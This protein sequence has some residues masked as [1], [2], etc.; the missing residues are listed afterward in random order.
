MTTKICSKC[1]KD[2]PLDNYY[3]I[4]NK[5]GKNYTYTYCRKCHYEKM[6]KHTSAKWRKDNPKKWRKAVHKSLY[7]W[8][9]R[10]N[11]GVYL[12]ITTKGLYVGASDKIRARVMQ[13]NGNQPGNVG[14]KGAKVI[15]WFTLEKVSNRKERFAAEMKWIKRLRPALNKKTGPKTNK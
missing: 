3:T 9:G 14:A 10:M 13:H 15:T 8:Y 11:K 12:L 4:L 2:L 1:D 6:T 7:D 5:R